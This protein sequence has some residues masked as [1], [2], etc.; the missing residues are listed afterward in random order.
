[1]PP[2]KRLGAHVEVAAQDGL[3]NA[4]FSQIEIRDVGP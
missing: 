3:G 4:D 1:V 2:I